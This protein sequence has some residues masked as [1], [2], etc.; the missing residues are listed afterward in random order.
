[1]QNRDFRPEVLQA[2]GTPVIVF[3]IPDHEAINAELAEIILQR[4]RTDRGL[5]RSNV[6]SWHS[7]EDFV[8]WGGRHVQ[9][10]AQTFASLC[11]GLTELPNQAGANGRQW[12]ARMWAN[13]FEQGALNRTHCHPGAFWSGTYYV[14]D[15]RRSADED[16]GADLV[17]HSP[18]EMVSSMYAPDVFIRLPNGQRL[19][20]TFTV[21]PRPGLGVI[22][23]SWLM[24]EVDPYRGSTV[25][26]SIAFNF[27]L[28]SGAGPSQQ[29]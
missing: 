11:S 24:H 3:D 12:V 13:V 18:H 2:F 20:T 29:S 27:S 25:R 19:P 17:L 15:G 26:I 6:N 16:V 4:R 14:N 5:V 23:P 7:D 9:Q 21:R 10:L 22:F 1:M 28:T 8:K